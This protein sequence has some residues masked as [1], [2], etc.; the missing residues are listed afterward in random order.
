MDTSTTGEPASSI[1][2]TVLA[3]ISFSFNSR[4]ALDMYKLSPADFLSRMSLFFEQIYNTYIDV[5][6]CGVDRSY[7]MALVSFFIDQ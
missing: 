5:F 2:L 6:F 4:S 1:R 7:H 3:R